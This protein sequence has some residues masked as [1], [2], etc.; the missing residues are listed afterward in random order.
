MGY[1][2]VNYSLELWKELTNA[3]NENH[4]VFTTADRAHL[5]NDVFAL[6]DATQLDYSVAMNMSSYLN[7]ELDYV[8]WK[9]GTAR[10]AAVYNLLYL[11]V[12][13]IQNG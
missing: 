12:D 10:L 8:P 9:V 13:D 6:A 5:L 1:Y 3:L 2:R 7:K 4:T 11:F